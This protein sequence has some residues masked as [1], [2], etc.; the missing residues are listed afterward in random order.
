MEYCRG[1][2]ENVNNKQ[3]AN[4]SFCFHPEQV[5]ILK[6]RQNKNQVSGQVLNLTTRRKENP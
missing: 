4:S 3:E 6:A 2:A 5:Y 1:Y